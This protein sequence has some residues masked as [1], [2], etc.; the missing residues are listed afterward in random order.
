ML[1]APFDLD[2]ITDLFV[3][4]VDVRAVHVEAAGKRRRVDPLRH[5]TQELQDGSVRSS[6]HQVGACSGWCARRTNPALRYQSSV[7][8]CDPLRQAALLL[9]SRR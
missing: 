4:G 3:D 2:E 6:S 7:R 8:P 5:A 9:E 1:D